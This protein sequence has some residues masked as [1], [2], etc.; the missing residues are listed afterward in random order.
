MLVCKIL[1]LTLTLVS[2]FRD[3]ACIGQTC[4]I[5]RVKENFYLQ[6]MS[7]HPIMPEFLKM[8]IDNTNDMPFVKKSLGK[9]GI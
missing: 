1:L 5:Q 2:L 9:S 3:I 4:S 6:F 8:V 7:T